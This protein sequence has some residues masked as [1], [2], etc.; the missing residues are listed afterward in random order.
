[1]EL[2]IH[3][4]NLSEDVMDRISGQADRRQ[5]FRPTPTQATRSIAIA[6][7]LLKHEISENRCRIRKDC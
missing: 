6:G 7:Y 1:M 3:K 4:D 2:Y 5:P